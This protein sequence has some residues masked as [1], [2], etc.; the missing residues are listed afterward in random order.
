MIAAFDPGKS[1]FAYVVGDHRLRKAGV[2]PSSNLYGIR[3]LGHFEGV[4]LA[5]V[6]DQRIHTYHKKDDVVPLA[7]TAGGL[8]HQFPRARFV[9]STVKKEWRHARAMKVLDANE[10]ALIESLSAE[11]Q[12]HVKCALYFYL[13]HVGRI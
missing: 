7:H 6:E 11:H 9:W 3:W 5:L 12:G 10:H 4:E 1:Y 8:Y 13:K 2:L